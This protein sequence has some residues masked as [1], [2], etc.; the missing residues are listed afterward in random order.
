VLILQWNK[1]NFMCS[2]FSVFTI[3]LFSFWKHVNL[4]GKISF[5]FLYL[6][7]VT[8]WI[9]GPFLCC[10]LLYLIIYL[11]PRNYTQERPTQIYAYLIWRIRYIGSWSIH[12]LNTSLSILQGQ[13]RKHIR[14][15]VKK[16]T[17]RTRKL[18]NRK[19]TLNQ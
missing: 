19:T 7:L 11:H 2:L 15:E 3:F 5:F 13:C 17:V 4:C 6:T 14:F 9:V 16:H 12:F 8:S 18:C 1:C 10:H